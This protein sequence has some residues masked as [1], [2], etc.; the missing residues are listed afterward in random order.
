MPVV[1]SA[2]WNRRDPTREGHFPSR[3]GCS[4]NRLKYPCV[5]RLH[6]VQVMIG[7][8]KAEFYIR[9]VHNGDSG[10][11]LVES[12]FAPP[13]TLPSSRGYPG[14]CCQF[15]EPAD[16]SAATSPVT[17]YSPPSSHHQPVR[18]RVSQVG[19]FVSDLT[20]SSRPCRPLFASWC[21]KGSKYYCQISR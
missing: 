17:P 13:A 19:S 18:R 4:H 1:E 14:G 2:G 3:F 7:M 12:L 16:I 6:L 11:G 15:L 8:P 5:D 21:S 10:S 9:A 20:R